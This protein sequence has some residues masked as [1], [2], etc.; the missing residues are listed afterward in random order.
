LR[1]LLETNLSLHNFVSSA[2]DLF[3]T[4]TL[5]RIEKLASKK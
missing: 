4:Q 2:L 3:R 5:A 1:P